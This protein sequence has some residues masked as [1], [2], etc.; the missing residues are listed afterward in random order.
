[1][2]MHVNAK[3]STFVIVKFLTFVNMVNFMLS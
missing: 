3:M 1:M 2:L